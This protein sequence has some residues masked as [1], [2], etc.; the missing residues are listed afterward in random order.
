MPDL[1]ALLI[2]IGV[3]LGISAFLIGWWQWPLAVGGGAGIV[4]GG[5]ALIGTMSVGRDPSE[6]DAAF[7]KAAPDLV[8]S[9]ASPTPGVPNR[10]PGPAPAA[11]GD[12][13][14]VAAADPER[15]P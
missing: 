2:A 10:P 6:A 11:S 5:L 1:R 9:P 4:L 12:Q 13:A 8:D 3:G 14:V 7:R 15:A